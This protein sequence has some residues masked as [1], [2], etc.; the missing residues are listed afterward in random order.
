MN[1]I[2]DLLLNR[3]VYGGQLNQNYITR[4]TE[5][6][7]SQEIDRKASALWIQASGDILA[8]ISSMRRLKVYDFQKKIALVY[9]SPLDA[10]V[11]K[12]WFTGKTLYFIEK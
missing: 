6:K 8:C 5:R 9:S 7:I 11:F 12:A 1:R 2:Q 10:Q 4:W 3:E